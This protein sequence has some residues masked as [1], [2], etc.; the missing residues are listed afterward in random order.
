MNRKEEEE[1]EEGNRV[2]TGRESS[3]V[4]NQDLFELHC[5]PVLPMDKP[6]E[7]EGTLGK[8]LHVFFLTTFKCKGG[9]H[10]I[11]KLAGHRY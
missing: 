10:P 6:D 7:R 9:T 2:G 3:Y 11:P 8:C 4:M 5:N 1:E